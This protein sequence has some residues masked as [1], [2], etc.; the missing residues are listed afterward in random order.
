M[1][2]GVEFNISVTQSLVEY[3][4]QASSFH[5]ILVIQDFKYSLELINPTRKVLG[6]SLSYFVHEPKSNSAR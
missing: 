5:E 1:K 3:A 2:G 4:F 6:E